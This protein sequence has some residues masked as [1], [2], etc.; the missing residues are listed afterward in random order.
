M[1]FAIFRLG[2]ATLIIRFSNKNINKLELEKYFYGLFK[3]KPIF[4]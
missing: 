2:I 4:T 3:T 1:T